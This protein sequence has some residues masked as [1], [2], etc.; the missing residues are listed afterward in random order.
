VSPCSVVEDVVEPDA[1]M[2]V[3]L[4]E[5]DRAVIE[6]LDEGRSADI[7]EIRRLLGG[8]DEILGGDVHGPALSH[9]LD[10]VPERGPPP[11]GAASVHRSRL[12]GGRAPGGSG[13]SAPARASS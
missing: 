13:G 2:P 10:R 4:V 6:E 5:R 7:E 12:G 3:G 1:T 11:R 8:E 9:D